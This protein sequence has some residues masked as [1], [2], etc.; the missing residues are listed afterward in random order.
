REVQLQLGPGG[1]A[2][3]DATDRLGVEALR[4]RDQ[5]FDGWLRRQ[6][7]RADDRHRSAAATS[8]APRAVA[9]RRRRR[10]RARAFAGRGIA[11][12]GVLT[13]VPVAVAVDVRLDVGVVEDGAVHGLAGGGDIVGDFVAREIGCGGR[14]ALLEPD[15]GNT[16]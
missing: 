5:A 2:G 12:T 8:P 4:L 1:A 15:F 7:R 9:R 13:D 6:R 10:R 3:G 16:P 11:R 14:A